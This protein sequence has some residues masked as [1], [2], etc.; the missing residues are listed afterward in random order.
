M[1]RSVTGL[2]MDQRHVDRIVGALIDAGF[3]A[4]RIS[5]VSPDDQAAGE[6][7]PAHQST[8]RDRGASAWLV[9]HLHR[10]GLSPEYTQR[11]QERVAQERRLVSVTVTTDAEDEEARNLM[12]ET[13]ATEISSAA[14][15]T[16]VPVQRSSAHGAILPN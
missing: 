2:F 10:H 12:V 1:A 13:G 6:A 11:Y 14:D 8:T 5:V 16:M 3:G 7:T 9:A 4:E 15:G